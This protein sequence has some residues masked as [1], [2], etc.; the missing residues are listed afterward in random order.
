MNRN[1]RLAK[2]RCI[3]CAHTL[4][5]GDHPRGCPVCE[6]AGRPSSLECVYIDLPTTLRPASSGFAW[7]EWLPYLS[8]VSLGE[9]QTP[10]LELPRLAAELGMARISAKHEGM[11]PTG[12]HKD[13]M[14]AQA[15]T[16]ALDAGAKS[17][18]LASS[19]NAAV[20]A[21]AYCAAAGLP[22]EVATYNAMPEGFVRAL[23]RLGARRI[24]F[25]RGTERWAHVRRRVEEEGAFALTN[26]CLPPVGSPAFGVEG[27]RALALECAHDGCVPDHVL[28]PTA[29]GDLLWG[30]YS[31]FL[32]LHA[33]G[34]VDRLPKMW[35]V[36]PFG[37]LSKVLAG[38][39][40]QQEFPGSTAQFSIAGG[41][42]TLQ[43]VH[44]V[45][46]S[47]GGAVVAD[48][49]QA[50]RG[51]DR[52]AREG[53]WVELCAGATVAALADLIASK[54]IDPSEHALLVLTAKG[55]RDPFEPAALS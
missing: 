52:L 41:T 21:A 7:G 55:D 19:G 30:I 28:V 14:S 35:V 2:L 31:G 12:S 34:L 3:S 54:Q 16:R 27:Y 32:D 53:L 9:G 44:A 17:V 42:V 26:Y 10:C 46:R 23:Q 29:R 15:V 37:R 5:L 1:P 38:A 36:E 24:G 51:A 25:E 45:R 39:P 43:Q 13:R 8:G 18:V 40:A 47:G 48:D 33:A 22:C 20:S 50:L 49:A 4:P 6:R 11:N